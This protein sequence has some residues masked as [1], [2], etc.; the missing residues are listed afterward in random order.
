MISDF[1]NFIEGFSICQADKMSQISLE[2]VYLGNPII[3]FRG[4]KV[5]SHFRDVLGGKKRLRI[6]GL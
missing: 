2:F 5:T 4:D 3:R 6:V 1:S